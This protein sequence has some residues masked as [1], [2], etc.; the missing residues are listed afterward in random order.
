VICDGWEISTVEGVVAEGKEVG[1]R[2]RVVK[3]VLGRTATK[4]RAHYSRDGSIAH[5]YWYG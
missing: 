5:Q 4:G 3:V 1:G 2:S